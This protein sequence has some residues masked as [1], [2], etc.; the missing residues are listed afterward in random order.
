MSNVH[1]KVSPGKV[2]D[3]IRKD[4]REASKQ[5]VKDMVKKFEGMGFKGTDVLPIIKRGVKE[6]ADE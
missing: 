2:A 3:N 5:V 1:E 4:A 6:G